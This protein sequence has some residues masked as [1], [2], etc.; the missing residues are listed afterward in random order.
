M[1]TYN[2]LS[3][4]ELGQNAVRALMGYPATSLPPVPSFDGAGVYTIHYRGDF[5]AYRGMADHE[6]VYV[7]KADPPGKRQGRTSS[8]GTGTVLHD[9]LTKHSQSIGQTRNLKLEDFTCRWLI[10]DEVWIGLTEQVLIA[11]YQPLWNTIVSGF[12]INAPGGGRS[13]QRKS[14]WDTLHPGRPYAEHRPPNDETEAAILAKIREHR[15]I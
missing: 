3:V 7:G 15:G 6:P 13:T 11:E 2:P 8:R 4:D 12:G 1:R 5:D 10:L 14:L 9:R